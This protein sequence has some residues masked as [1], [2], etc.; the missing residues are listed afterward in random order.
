MVVVLVIKLPDRV[1][2]VIVVKLPDWAAVVIVVIW[3]DRM[4]VVIVIKLHY[5]CT[6]FGHHVRKSA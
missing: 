2:V 4:V 6:N 3:P 1:L 5:R